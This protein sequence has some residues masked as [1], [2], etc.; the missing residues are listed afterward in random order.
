MENLQAGMLVRLTTGSD[1]GNHTYRLG[2]RSPGGSIG[3]HVESVDKPEIPSRTFITEDEIKEVADP[4]TSWIKDVL[5][6][7]GHPELP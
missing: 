5:S 1:F 6:T 4:F 3:W 2:L 7:H